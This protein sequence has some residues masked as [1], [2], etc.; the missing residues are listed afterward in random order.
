MAHRY[1]EGS[2]PAV[3][4]RDVHP[5]QGGW[6]VAVPP[7]AVH[8]VDLLLRRV[9]D[10]SVHAG[11][12]LSLAFGDPLDGKELAAE[13]VGQQ[14]LQ[15]FHLVPSAFPRCLH[16]TGLE[17]THRPSRRG[18]VELVPRRYRAG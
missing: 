13:R 9:P 6:P 17:P 16:D 15:G 14:T 12:V 7:E 2:S 4:L 8:R 3:R 18:P 5:P 10:L 1:P 11:G